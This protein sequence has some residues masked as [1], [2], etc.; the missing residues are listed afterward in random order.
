MELSCPYA[1]GEEVGKNNEQMTIEEKTVL[2]TLPQSSR[3]AGQ[4]AK[5]EE[6]VRSVVEERR[7]QRG[8]AR[9]KSRGL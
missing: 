9:P 8:V 6:T 3:R 5:S 4:S 1:S 2:I 7:F